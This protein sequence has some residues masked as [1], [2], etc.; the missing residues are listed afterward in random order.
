MSQTGVN[1]RQFLH[2]G[3][4]AVATAAAMASAMTVIDPNA[5]WSM[6]TKALTPDTAQALLRM[7]R[8]LYPHDMLADVYYGK[9]VEALDAGADDDKLFNDLLNDG[10]A[11]LDA[12]NGI[13]FVDLS[14]GAQ[15]AAVTSIEDSDFFVAVRDTTVWTL[16]ANP[17]IWR[18][19][20]YEGPSAEYG[21]YLERGFDDIAWLPKV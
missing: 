4:L 21:G 11:G 9:V 16:Y 3:G 17:L 7:S 19:F 10:V 5:A 15:L 12:I 18:Y 13:P 20:G 2:K 14:R 8:T 6:T 1:R